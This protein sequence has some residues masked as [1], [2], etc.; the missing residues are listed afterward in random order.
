MYGEFVAILS[1]CV[2]FV[3]FYL[4]VDLLLCHAR[5][6]KDRLYNS[7]HF[8]ISTSSFHWNTPILPLCILLWQ[9]QLGPKSTRDVPFATSAKFLHTLHR[10]EGQRPVETQRPAGI[11]ESQLEQRRVRR[12][13][14]ARAAGRCVLL[15]VQP[16][17]GILAGRRRLGTDRDSSRPVKPARRQSSIGGER[18]HGEDG[19]RGRI[20]L[21]LDTRDGQRGAQRQRDVLRPQ[22]RLRTVGDDRDHGVRTRPGDAKRHHPPRFAAGVERRPR[23]AVLGVGVDGVGNGV[24]RLRIAR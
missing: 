15:S 14:H 1:A 11:R 17:P 13:Q 21:G 19:V 20:R 8:H 18:G 16:N 10:Y 23:R 9:G 3:W 4:L 7:F 6:G 22:E 12:L 5:R 24:P 2:R